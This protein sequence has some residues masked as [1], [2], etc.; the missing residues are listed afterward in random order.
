MC[1]RRPHLAGYG[2]LAT[3]RGGRAEC[4]Q[5]HGRGKSVDD[6]L[7][8]AGGRPP[9]FGCTIRR[10]LAG[11]RSRGGGPGTQ[12]SG[13]P[14]TRHSI[15]RLVLSI[16]AAAFGG[17][18]VVSCGIVRVGILPGEPPVSLALPEKQRPLPLTPEQIRGTACETG[19]WPAPT[20]LRYRSRTLDALC[21]RADAA[22]WPECTALRRDLPLPPAPRERRPLLPPE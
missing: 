19:D 5:C 1:N 7:S 9:V 3:T 14:V 22:D 21:R 20:C 8:A 11:A 13:V 15:R 2:G 18:V 17:F 12:I 6:P 4:W 16:T 10:T